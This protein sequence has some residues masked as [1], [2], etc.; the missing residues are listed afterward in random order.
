MNNTRANILLILIDMSS[1]RGVVGLGWGVWLCGA[2]RWL[3]RSGCVAVQGWVCGCAGC[4]DRVLYV[5]GDALN[6]QTEVQTL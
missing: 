5:R 3:C 1:I 2:G 4:G 6:I